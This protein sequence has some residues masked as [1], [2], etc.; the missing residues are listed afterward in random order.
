VKRTIV[1]GFGVLC[2]A[3]V[4]AADGAADE[5]KAKPTPAFKPPAGAKVSTSP[6]GLQ[7]IDVAVGKGEG[8]RP[9][10]LCIVHYTAWLEDGTEVDTSTRP[11]P[12][13][14]RDPSKGEKVL[15]FGF[16]LG[17]GQ[18]IPG[19]DEGVAGMRE[20][21]TRLLFIPPQLGYGSR[22]IG[23]VVPPDAR[24]TFRVQ[25]LKVKREPAPT[26]AAGS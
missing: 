1:L 9:G 6:T 16:K 21:G 13:D 23:K 14:P 20:G 24:L 7:Y 8:P 25:L 5:D 19:W 3:A 2:C 4:L 15:P 18:V 22:G 10:D 26:P 17:S 11:R 12:R